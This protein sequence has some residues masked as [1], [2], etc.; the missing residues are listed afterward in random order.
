MK[1]LFLL[2]VLLIFT[3][4]LASC[5]Q[6]D[7]RDSSMT[8]SLLQH[9]GKWVV[10]NYWATWCKPCI[11]E[12]PELNKLYQDSKAKNITVIGVSFDPMSREDINQ[13]AKKYHIDYPLV[14]E[15]PIEKYGVDNIPTV[16]ATFIFSP[17]GKLVKTLYG[18]QKKK[19]LEEAIG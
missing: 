11:T 18:A 10:V 2:F 19:Q 17:Q 12:M 4:L 13:F 1:K 15:F 16:P 14:T 9:K 7:Q 8:A 6:S 3:L 5:S